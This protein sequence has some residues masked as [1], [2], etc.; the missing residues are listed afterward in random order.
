MRHD[1]SYGALRRWLR[2][3]SE[4]RTARSDLRLRALLSTIFA[5]LFLVGAGA[6]AWLA[7]TAGAGSSPPR[8][9]WIALA[10]IC[11]AF[12]L[13]SLGD[14]AVVRRREAESRRWGR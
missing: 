9:A 7:S 3:G 5:P 13:I 8:G 4:P 10:A 6:F 14:L 11:A 12:L 2:T 1:P